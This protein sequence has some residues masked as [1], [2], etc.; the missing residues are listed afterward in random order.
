LNAHERVAP[1]RKEKEMEMKFLAV[2]F[3]SVLLDLPPAEEGC[4]CNDDDD[5][6]G[7]AAYSDVTGGDEKVDCTK[8]GS[9]CSQESLKK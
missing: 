9:V 4:S 6:N 1:H 3:S 5:F 7:Q 8:D 2:L